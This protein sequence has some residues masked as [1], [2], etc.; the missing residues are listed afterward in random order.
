MPAVIDPLPSWAPEGSE[1]VP[2]HRCWCAGWQQCGVVGTA[3]GVWLLGL[4]IYCLDCARGIVES[5]KREGEQ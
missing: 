4:G 5:E 1:Y 3:P 2:Y